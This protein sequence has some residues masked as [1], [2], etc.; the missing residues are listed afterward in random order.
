[1]KDKNFSTTGL[2]QDPF[3]Y[4]SQQTMTKSSKPLVAGILLIIAGVL[5]ILYWT[6]IS[7]IDLSTFMELSQLKEFYPELTIEQIEGAFTAC[8]IMGG[9]ISVV[10]I[11]GGILT[12]KRKLW[13]IALLGAILGLFI[14]GPALIS[15]FLSL[16]AII[17]IVIS[18][19]EFQ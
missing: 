13:A 16:I 9:I 4:T 2:H 8:A 6:L 11:L 3:G 14:I 12:L 19:A 17:L 15:S 1:M 7:T 5:A 18:K 10:T